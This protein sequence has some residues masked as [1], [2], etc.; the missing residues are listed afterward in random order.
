M[1]SDLSAFATRHLTLTALGI[2]KDGS[3]GSPTRFL[4]LIDV[5]QFPSLCGNLGSWLERLF[6]PRLL[7]LMPVPDVVL[8]KLVALY[9]RVDCVCELGHSGY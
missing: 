3:L 6:H 5:P 7:K 4:T 9:V 2:S 1:T 8:I